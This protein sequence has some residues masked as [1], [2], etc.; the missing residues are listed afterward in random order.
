MN[1]QGQAE[2]HS[3]IM[4][5]KKKI[6]LW[7]NNKRRQ[8]E[9]GEKK[10]PSSKPDSSCEEMLGISRIPGRRI[11][12]LASVFNRAPASLNRL[13]RVPSALATLVTEG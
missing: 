6:S 4:C 7:F 1:I 2:P 3:K 10:I 9:F 11:T 12:T 8:L 5:Q 13:T